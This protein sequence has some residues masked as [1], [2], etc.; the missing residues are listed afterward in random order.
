LHSGISIGTD[1]VGG[2]LYLVAV[3]QEGAAQLQGQPAG[4]GCLATAGIAQENDPSVTT[5]DLG[6]VIGALLSLSLH[7]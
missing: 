6:Q 4:Q 5:D 7:V 3:I 2:N 1:V